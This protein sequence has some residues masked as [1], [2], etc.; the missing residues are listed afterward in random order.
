MVLLDPDYKR[1]VVD[2]TLA[3]NPDYL[4]KF[5]GSYEV[6][7]PGDLPKQK[8]QISV[9]GKL[10]A[11]SL[12]GAE[13]GMLYPEEYG[14]F[15]VKGFPDGKVY[16]SFDNEGNVSKVQALLS[17]GTILWEAIPEIKEEKTEIDKNN[18]RQ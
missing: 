2:R 13:W 11:S 6:T 7:L 12:S 3:N 14:V 5:V 15:G 4:N 8:L 18:E 9:F 16:F 1:P 10:L 17:D